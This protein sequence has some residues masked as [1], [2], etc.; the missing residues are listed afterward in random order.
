MVGYSLSREQIVYAKNKA[1]DA[2]LD[3]LV[4]FYCDD[5]RAAGPAWEG[6]AD[7]VV[8]IGMMEHVGHEHFRD[9]FETAERVMKKGPQAQ[10]GKFLIHT[11]TSPDRD[12]ARYRLRTGFIQ[13]YIFPGCCIPA[14]HAIVES[15][16][17][18]SPFELQHFENLGENCKL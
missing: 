18:S 8:S 17:H 15:M 4:E 14:V 5:Y 10:G 13:H 1:K 11:I 6:Q 3:H 7:H 9:M 12:Y 2:G 16:A